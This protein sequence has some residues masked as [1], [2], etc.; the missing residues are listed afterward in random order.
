LDIN[1]EIIFQ[2]TVN[3]Q[4]EV[5]PRFVQRGLTNSLLAVSPTWDE[6]R[7][8]LE[9]L[10]RNRQVLIWNAK[11][12]G[13]FFDLER[14]FVQDV[15]LRFSPYLGHWDLGWGCYHFQRL[16][17]AMR[18]I[19]A[20]YCEP[21]KHRAVP[22][23]RAALSVWDWCIKN[24]LNTFSGFQ[25]VNSISENPSQSNPMFGAQN[26]LEHHLSEE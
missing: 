11:H 20:T 6:V 24:P 19:G 18:L 4:C 26:K 16:P 17:R 14:S 25:T 15:M 22:D 23:C 10:M 12:E 21:G 13:A 5:H 8:F 1:G 2:T 7:P 3:P 9:N